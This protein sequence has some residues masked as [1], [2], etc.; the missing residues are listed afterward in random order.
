MG[1]R[2]FNSIFL[3]ST[4]REE[5]IKIVSNLNDKKSSGLD[6]IDN[7]LLKNIIEH[8][9]DP[10]VHIINLS[11]SNGIV[12]ENMKVAKVIPVFKKGDKN[13]VSNYR[14]ISLLTSMSKILERIIYTRTYKFLHLNNVF[15]DFQF[16]FREKHCTSH[17]LLTFLE[18][19]TQSLDKFCHMIGI[20]LD[21]SKAFDTINHEILI[22]KL[23]HYGIRGKA[24][25]WFRSYLSNRQQLVSFNGYNSQ[26]RKIECGVPQ[27]SL[28]GP[29]LFI[30][31][32]NDFHRSSNTLSFILFADDSNLFL[33]HPDPH[34]LLNTVNEELKLVTQWI[35]ANKL[36]L[37][38]AKTKYM[39]FSNS[40]ENLPGDII[41]DGTPLENVSWTTFL[42]VEVDNK[43]TWKY[44][45]NSIC[46]KISRNIG[47][48]NRLKQYFPSST[49]L[50]LYSSL[51]LPY[52][53]YG[54][55]VWGNTHQ[56][57]LDKILLLQKKSLRIIFNLN[58]RAHTDDLFCSNRL[59]K[60]K[61]LYLF[62]LGQF[63]FNYKKNNLPKVF[64][65]IFYRNERLHN[66]PTRHS[67]EY[68]LPL[69]RTL[70]AQNTF[71]F[72]GPRFWNNLNDVHKNA[73][74]LPSFKRNLKLFLLESY[75]TQ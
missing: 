7:R 46:K 47:V 27:G 35:H 15:T 16:G 48:I 57:L 8:I 52:L 24:L 17:A 5:I 30:I 60:V 9:V 41:F 50:M 29:L 31:Y 2:N 42:G 43:L 14:P 32:M 58:M 39:I 18:K 1:R 70:L 65:K 13:D 62:Q 45:I 67:N 4:H 74:S 53:N 75:T 56:S 66:Y 12:P 54:I 3:V 21:F 25:D 34:I 38:L 69:L 64:D 49:L 59:L 44:H 68:H 72:T 63:M 36:S 55:L 71:V 11:I 20:F 61:D 40:I 19:A 10:M 33:S 6:D 22:N 28:L 23:Y 73:S 26:M 51:I 37:N